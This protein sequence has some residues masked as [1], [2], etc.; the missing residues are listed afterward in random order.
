MQM[1]TLR[2][3]PRARV[4]KQTNK[5]KHLSVLEK[6][7]IEKTRA[8]RRILGS[9]SFPFLANAKTK[10]LPLFHQWAK[11]LF[12]DDTNAQP[13]RKRRKITK[14][15]TFWVECLFVSNLVRN[16]AMWKTIP[17][18]FA[19]CQSA[20]E[21]ISSSLNHDIVTHHENKTRTCLVP[22][23]CCNFAFQ[24]VEKSLTAPWTIWQ[25]LRQIS[26]L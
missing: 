25:N 23:I 5:Q 19:R 20:N 9:H 10:P 26:S 15:A 3:L 17:T 24:W 4:N 14:I 6:R 8:K 12:I 16:F 11:T 2:M 7:Y 21:G 1:N 13:R 22:N 18:V